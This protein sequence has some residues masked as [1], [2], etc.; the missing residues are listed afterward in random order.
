MSIL[1]LLMRAFW[2]NLGVHTGPISYGF[3]PFY[4]MVALLVP[5]GEEKVF[6]LYVPISGPL[7]PLEL[8]FSQTIALML[9][10]AFL[11]VCLLL[12]YARDVREAGRRI[13]ERERE[14]RLT[15][16]VGSMSANL[17]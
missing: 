17:P 3:T 14:V 8:T 5:S 11:F 4:A 1:R 16:R 15:A 7:M 12:S 2:F 13:E 9:F 6:R 10:I